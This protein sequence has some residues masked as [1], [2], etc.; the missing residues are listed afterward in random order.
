M[1]K[2]FFMKQEER[3]VQPLVLAELI[4]FIRIQMNKHPQFT[5]F[6]QQEKIND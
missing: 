4:T 2:E 6:M 3:M 5:R 1:V